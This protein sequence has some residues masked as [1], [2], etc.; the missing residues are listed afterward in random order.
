MSKAL[1]KTQQ[2]VYCCLR[3]HKQW[4]RGCGWLWDTHGGT[5]KILDSL[6]RRGLVTKTVEYGRDVYR[7]V[8]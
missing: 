7:P 3:G 2:S 5:A 8:L 1:G 6:V 4:S